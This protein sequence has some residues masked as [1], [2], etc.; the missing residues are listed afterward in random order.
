MNN[1][2]TRIVDIKPLATPNELAK[3]YPVSDELSK[4]ISESRK[5]V[6]NILKGEDH[7]LL[8]IVVCCFIYDREAL[9]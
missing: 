2:D 3:I 9:L 5:I 7:R 1:K 8:A 6:E 4:K